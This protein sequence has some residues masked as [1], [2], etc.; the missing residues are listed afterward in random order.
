MTRNLTYFSRK[1][2]ISSYYAIKFLSAIL[3]P[4]RQPSKGEVIYTAQTIVFLELRTPATA[5]FGAPLAT[6]I[7]ITKPLARNNILCC[8]LYE[9]RLIDNVG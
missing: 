8:D 7:S 6:E 9:K 3:L 4:Y 1:S 5:G 2:Q